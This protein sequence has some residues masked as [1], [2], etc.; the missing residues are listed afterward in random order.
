MK[1]KSTIIISLLF[2][3]YWPLTVVVFNSFNN[4]RFGGPWRGFTT[5]WY[6]ML[7]DNEEIW[8]AAT[9]S[10]IIALITAI[11]ATFLGLI[12]A[13]AMLKGKSAYFKTLVYSSPAAPDILQG[14][15]LLLFFL[16]TS[17]LLESLTGISL[18]LG[19]STV[20][21]AHITFSLAFTVLILTARLKNLDPRL[22]E[23]AMDLGCTK[24]KAF[25][26]VILPV[27][28]P[29]IVAA[30]LAAFTLSMDDFIITFFVKGTG[31]NTLPVYIQGAMRR[32]NPAI[33]NALSTV[34]IIFAAFSVTIMQK[35][36]RN[37]K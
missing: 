9:N 7:V 33:L 37:N 13:F 23:A 32:G 8:L 26:K 18:Q 3:L 17:S 24:F 36:F 35:L 16:Y 1:L 21:L 10:L 25:T 34:L 5:K 2:F 12:G 28:S 22:M 11:C 20:I 14:I 6:Q 29:G 30:G 31:D 4:S 15:S 27:I 19:N